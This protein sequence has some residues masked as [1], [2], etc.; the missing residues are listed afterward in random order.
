MCIPFN[1]DFAATVIEYIKFYDPNITIIHSTCAIGTTREIWNSFNLGEVHPN[2]VHCPING[3]HP[4][5][6]KDIRLYDMFV[7]SFGEDWGNEVCDYIERFGIKT[8][9]FDTPESTE[10][11]KIASTEYC[12]T[13]VEFFGRMKYL[14]ELDNSKK[15]RA[16]CLL[17]YEKRL[18]WKEVIIF[19]EALMNKGDGWKRMYRRGN[20]IDTK[21]SGKHCLSSNKPL[22]DKYFQ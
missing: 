5:M 10:F 20:R 2:I 13:M 11:C 1:K 4:N 16:Y 21:M 12:R 3:R 19:F 17:S 9:L 6:E 8:Y 7:G 18:S 15:Y 22:L 14:V